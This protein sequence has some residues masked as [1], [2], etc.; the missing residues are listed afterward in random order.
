MSDDEH[1]MAAQE[2]AAMLR[3]LDRAPPEG[4]LSDWQ[5]RLRAKEDEHERETQGVLVFRLFDE[6]LA[7]EASIVKEIT[8]DATIH[9]I[10]QRTNNVLRGLVNVRGEL[11]LCVSLHALLNLERTGE[12]K[13]LSRRVHPRMIVFQGPDGA[14][15]F[16]A[17]EA[18]GVHALE[19]CLLEES[20]VTVSKAMAT[21]TRGLFTLL[22]T[23]V[24]LLDHELIFH[25]LKTQHL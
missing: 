20:P 5:D 24:G 14:F 16:R 11:Q 3:L 15:V 1:E 18:Y 17:E 23:K 22:D 13:V 4:Y 9:R 7:I 2:R 8:A 10:P 21:F 6:W 19:K 25:S 12:E